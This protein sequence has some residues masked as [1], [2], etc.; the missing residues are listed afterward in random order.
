MA[1]STTSIF[2]GEVATKDSGEVEE[3]TSASPLSLLLTY[4][5]RF[6]GSSSPLLGREE[7]SRMDEEAPEAAAAEEV[8]KTEGNLVVVTPLLLLPPLKAAAVD[9]PPLPPPPM[10]AAKLSRTKPEAA[11]ARD[12]GRSLGDS[13]SGVY[14]FRN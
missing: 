8:G 11:V 13:G 9:I 2:K 12:E 1:V 10:A 6:A 5:P 3:E 14:L 4:S 7:H